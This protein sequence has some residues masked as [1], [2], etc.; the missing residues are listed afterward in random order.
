MGNKNV[1][2]SFSALDEVTS[3]ESSGYLMR[4]FKG[5]LISSLEKIED[6]ILENATAD[7]NLLVSSATSFVLLFLYLLSLGFIINSLSKAKQDI[8]QLKISK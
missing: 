5:N 3:D 7:E 1:R 2:L 4:E 6:Q 8:R